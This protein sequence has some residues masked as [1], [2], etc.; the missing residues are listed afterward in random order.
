MLEL[1]LNR[2]ETV[3]QLHDSGTFQERS[4]NKRTSYKL[5]RELVPY[6]EPEMMK[7][8]IGAG[9]QNWDSKFFSS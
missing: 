5:V 8:F 9:V 6:P 1:I 3:Q 7:W 4:N 2:L